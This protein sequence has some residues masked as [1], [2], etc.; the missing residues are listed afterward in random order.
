MNIKKTVII[1][2]VLVALL[3]VGLSFIKKPINSPE[4]NIKE[5]ETVGI[6]VVYIDNINNQQL[7][8]VYNNTLNTATI[9]P[10]E[11]NQVVFTATTSGSGAR[12]ENSNQ[13]L[14][15]WN[16]GYDVSLYLN[17]SL[18]FT[19]TDISKKNEDNISENSDSK[20]LGSWAW[21][22]TVLSNKEKITPKNKDVF[23]ITFKDDG[24]V[25]G[26]TDCNGFGGTYSNT[27]VVLTFGPFAS[28]LMYCEGSQELEF[29]SYLGKTINYSIQNNSELKLITA[30]NEILIFKRK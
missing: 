7:K 23:S 13:G 5:E 14:I 20:I 26:K 6:E 11:N 12:Y 21:E 10:N 24:N 27:D 17:D 30:D 3:F 29:T 1:I 18:I 25:S 4:T 9:Y 19:G 28:T 8:V 16:K 15:L 22:E 2:I